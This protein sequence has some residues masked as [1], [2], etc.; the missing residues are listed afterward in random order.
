M[1]KGGGQIEPLNQEKLPS[2]GSSKCYIST[3]TFC[4]DLLM[5]KNIINLNTMII[6]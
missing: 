2:K 1:R 4:K 3:C 5:S 6:T